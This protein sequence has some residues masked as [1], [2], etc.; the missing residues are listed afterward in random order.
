MIRC[1][2]EVREDPTW[3][4]DDLMLEITNSYEQINNSPHNQKVKNLLEAAPTLENRAPAKMLSTET[5]K[6]W[7]KDARRWCFKNKI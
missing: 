3:E 5:V 1:V 2:L 7:V 4:D 6:L